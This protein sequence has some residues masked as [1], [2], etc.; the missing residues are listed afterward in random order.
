[1]P[2]LPLIGVGLSPVLEWL[3]VPGF[4]LLLSRSTKRVPTALFGNR[5]H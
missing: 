2:R 4:A 1:M 3:V 5:H